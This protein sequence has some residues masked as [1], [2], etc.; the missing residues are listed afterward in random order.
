MTTLGILGRTEQEKAVEDNVEQSFRAEVMKKIAL[1]GSWSIG[2][3]IVFGFI[4][5]L[6]SDPHDAF[7][8]LKAW[9]PWAFFGLAALFIVYDIAK[10]M[11]TTNQR[12]THAF[13]KL[14]FAV[15]KLANKD[16]RAQQEMQTLTAYTAQQSEK[17]LDGMK[18]ILA[19]QKTHDAKEVGGGRA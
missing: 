13:E 8:M 14:A 19:W 10:I 2:A 4:E 11:L 17:M 7:P 6:R 9:G 12:Q 5:F 3:A 18:E 16:D 15:E 1:G